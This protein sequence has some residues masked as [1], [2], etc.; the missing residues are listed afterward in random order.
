MPQT[1]NENRKTKTK[2]PE[3]ARWESEGGNPDP[4]FLEAKNEDYGHKVVSVLQDMF[5]K[6]SHAT[7]SL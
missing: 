2:R 5:R 3:I 6:L 1:R 7:H 4:R